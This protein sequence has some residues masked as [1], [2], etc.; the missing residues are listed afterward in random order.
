MQKFIK[1]LFIL[2]IGISLSIAGEKTGFAS[3]CIGRH[4]PFSRF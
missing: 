3:E 2:A 1:Y 4:P